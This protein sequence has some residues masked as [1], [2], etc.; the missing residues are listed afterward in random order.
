[1]GLFQT[2][3]TRWNAEIP[4]FFKGVRKLSIVVGTSATAV[5]VANSG[6][7]L[8]LNPAILTVCKYIIAVCA[9]TGLTSQLTK[10]DTPVDN[11]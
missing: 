2:I 9:A 4:V 10:T 1:M 5:W 7:G 3:K 8:E 11:N 6:M